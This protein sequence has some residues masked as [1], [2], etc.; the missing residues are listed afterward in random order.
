MAFRKKVQKFL[1]KLHHNKHRKSSPESGS[2][3]KN[4][5]NPPRPST[6]ATADTVRPP[7]TNVYQHAETTSAPI[8]VPKPPMLRADSE[9]PREIN[10]GYI[11]SGVLSVNS[12]SA[13]RIGTLR[14]ET[15]GEMSN[16]SPHTSPTEQRFAS[17]LDPEDS[18]HF[19]DENN[20]QV[21][22]LQR[23]GDSKRYSNQT[24]RTHDSVSGLNSRP[25]DRTMS[26]VTTDTLAS[27]DYDQHSITVSLNAGPVSAAGKRVM[28]D[29]HNVE[30]PPVP[31]HPLATSLSGTTPS[32]ASR[33]VTETTDITSTYAAPIVNTVV[34]PVEQHTETHVVTTEHH[35]HHVQS[36]VQPVVEQHFLPTKYYLQSPSSEHLHEITAE[37]AAHYGEPINR[38]QHVVAGDDIEKEI[39]SLGQHETVRTRLPTPHHGHS[40]HTVAEPDLPLPGSNVD[41]GEMPSGGA[42]AHHAAAAH[43]HR[44]HH[45]HHHDDEIHDSDSY[46]SSLSDKSFDRSGGMRDSKWLQT[47]QDER[48]ARHELHRFVTEPDAAY[49]HGP[50]QPRRSIPVLRMGTFGSHATPRRPEESQEAS[51]HS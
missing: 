28:E 4:N 18:G 21:L 7:G 6:A 20:T 13:A 42:H 23:H 49:E 3:Q 30:I 40:D 10:P 47:Q 26:N 29:F 5:S 16:A 37:E 36:R 33:T 46:T 8:T 41:L 27:S 15:F 39:P 11:P 45:H 9:F 35:Y 19:V 51:S 24:L 38:G 2:P 12:V 22:G 44:H 31:T 50:V 25:V 34:K 43:A 14:R 32:Q 17:S 48:E 1:S